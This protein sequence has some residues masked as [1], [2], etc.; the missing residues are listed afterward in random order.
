MNKP[1]LICCLTS[2]SIGAYA[3]VAPN[4]F[5]LDFEGLKD[6]EKILDFYNGGTGSKGSKGPD[7][8]VRFGDS[9]LALIDKDVGGSGNSANYPSGKTE[10]FW[11][12]GGSVIMNVEKGFNTGF[13]FYYSS[14][15]ETTIT[16][17]DGINATG[18][19]LG[20]IKLKAQG[21]DNCTGDPT[22]YYCNWTPVGVAFEGMAKSVNF[23][24]TE[25]RT[26]FDNITFG[27]ATPIRD[28]SDRPQ[29][30]QSV[31]T[32]SLFGLLSSLVIVAGAAGRIL[33]KRRQYLS[34][35]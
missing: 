4:I 17:Y 24:G 1:I 14:D 23:A 7:Y 27:S 19:I 15:V 21:N 34:T 33:R 9:A 11:L 8:G 6:E 28:I 31:P 12:V 5:K 26:G 32:L 18:N 35:A 20:L 13:S 22:G 30:A 16:V 10:V 2:L 3:A 29:K 25:N